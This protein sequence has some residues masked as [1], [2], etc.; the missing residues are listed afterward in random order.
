MTGI[1]GIN[2]VVL[3]LGR[4]LCGRSGNILGKELNAFLNAVEVL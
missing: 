1:D 3:N 2:E 4:N